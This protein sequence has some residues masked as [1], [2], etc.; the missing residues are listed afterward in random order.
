MKCYICKKPILM[1]EEIERVVVT[2]KIDV[3]GK[4]K[5]IIDVFIMEHLKKEEIVH[6][7]CY[8]K[9]RRDKK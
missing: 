3:D 8:E 7:K 6:K 2:P 5:F 1:H 4:T 9:F